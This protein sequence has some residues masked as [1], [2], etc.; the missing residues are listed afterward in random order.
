MAGT[1]FGHSLEA[2][3]ESASIIKGG[4]SH[5][6]PLTGAAIAVTVRGGL[7]VVTVTRQLTNTEAVPIEAILTFP[8]GFEAAVTG[9]SAEVEGRVLRAEAQPKARARAEYE[10]A[11]DRG[12]LAVLHEEVLRGVHMLSVANLAPGASA[13]VVMEQVVPVARIADGGVLRLP[14]TVGQLYGSSPLQPADDVVTSAQALQVARLSVTS[15]GPV[16]LTG[17]GDLAG[18]EITVPLSRAIELTLAQ[19]AFSP[20]SGTTADGRSVTLSVAPAAADDRLDL[21]V[22]FDRSGS[23]SSAVG[24][25]TVWSAMQEGL[26]HCLAQLRPDDRILL[27]QFDDDCQILGAASG[28]DARRLLG[29]IKGPKGGTELGKAILKLVDFGAR[30]ILVMTD[31]QTWEHEMDAI[32]GADCRISAVLVGPGSLD[33]NIGHLVALKGGQL[34]YAPGE[35]VASALSPAF[36]AARSAAGEGRLSGHELTCVRGGMR[37]TASWSVAGSRTGADAVGRFAAA[38]QMAFLPPDGALRIALDHGL[39]SHLTSLVLVDEAGESQRL[40]PEQRKIGLAQ[41]SMA[42]PDLMPVASSPLPRMMK[43]AFSRYRAAPQALETPPAGQ[44]VLELAA[45]I[46][47]DAQSNAFLQGDLS[48]LTA[49]DRHLLRRQ[50]YRVCV[51]DLAAA[52]GV[53]IDLVALA[54]VAAEIAP[55]DIAALRFVRRVLGQDGMA[56]V[57][58]LRVEIA[59]QR[60]PAVESWV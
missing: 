23:T 47:W 60:R 56:E 44:D 57:Q 42:A 25:G 14:Q 59:A 52:R 1:A 51:L 48:A 35:D 4:K 33:A 20:V 21:A 31:G 10:D 41:P 29:K 32:A 26:A 3:Y 19:T 18:R 24:G 27:G 15:E 16:M 50:F 8:V 54:L 28:P 5:P 39:C 13:R 34:F 12:K 46:D 9:L 40:L 17:H 11:I 58:R 38:L 6:L 22:L 36:A 37:I 43:R 7:A 30:D 45:R 49:Q 55:Q 53:G 2:L